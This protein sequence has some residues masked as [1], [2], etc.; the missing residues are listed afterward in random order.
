MAHLF[1]YS[2]FNV[3]ELN[4]RLKQNNTDEL[5]NTQICIGG[6]GAGIIGNV[7]FGGWE[8]GRKET[9]GNDSVIINVDQYIWIL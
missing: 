7:M 5:S 1:L 6:G 9:I 2:F 8:A 4:Q 3:D